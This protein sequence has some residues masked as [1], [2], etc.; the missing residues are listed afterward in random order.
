MPTFD[1]G[2][3]ILGV[4][5]VKANLTPHRGL[6]PVHGC[7]NGG[8]RHG[9]VVFCSMLRMCGIV[10]LNWANEAIPLTSRKRFKCPHQPFRWLRRKQLRFP[11]ANRVRPVLSM[12]APNVANG[13]CSS[14][15]YSLRNRNSP[16]EP[17]CSF[18]RSAAEVGK[19]SCTPLGQAPRDLIQ[20][21]RRLAVHCAFPQKRVLD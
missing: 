14:S 16:S 12:I 3:R 5:V 21:S 15:A 20:L 13:P 6:P 18:A 11:N 10:T 2:R 8:F 1:A 17:T 9:K 19:C 7:A 4:A